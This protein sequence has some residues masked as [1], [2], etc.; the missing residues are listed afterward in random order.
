M[1][2]ICTTSLWWSIPFCLRF[3]SSASVQQ[4]LSRELYFPS[5]IL[6]EGDSMECQKTRKNG[7]E[8]GAEEK[9]SEPAVSHSPPSPFSFAWEMPC[10]ISDS[11]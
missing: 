11:T 5:L 8:G 1:V 10:N 2:T 3:L 6:L 9:S 7:M 4:G